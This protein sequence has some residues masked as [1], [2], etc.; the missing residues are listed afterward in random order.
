M[1]LPE[2]SVGE[3]YNRLFKEYTGFEMKA[4]SREENAEGRK[5]VLPGSYR[6][7]AAQ[8]MELASE[9]GAAQKSWRVSFKL[10]KGLYATT[11]INEMTACGCIQK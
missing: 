9:Y 10:K 1:I 5:L 3:E 11:M 2:T 7:I 6:V 8:P 4:L